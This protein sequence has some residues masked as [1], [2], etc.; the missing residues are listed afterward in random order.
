MHRVRTT[1]HSKQFVNSIYSTKD[2]PRLFPK[3]TTC[4]VRLSINSIATSRAHGFITRH[5]SIAFRKARP[6]QT[7]P[8]KLRAVFISK[9]STTTQSNS[10]RKS[11]IHIRNRQAHAM[12]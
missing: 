8:F 5:S 2:H 4:C 3:P 10:F 11:L 9:R 7:Q 1:S 6:C 12:H